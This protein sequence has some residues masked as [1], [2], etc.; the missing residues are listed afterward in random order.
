MDDATRTKL[1]S[2]LDGTVLLPGDPTYD[3]TRTI[4]NAIVDRRPAV[5]F[6]CASVGDVVTAVRTARERD[7]EIGIRCGGHSA[8]GHAVPDG[9]LMID[10]SPL[11]AVRVD[12]GQRRAVV[13]GGALLGALDR[14]SQQ[15]GL[16]ASVASPSAA[17][18]AGWLGRQVWLATTSC[19]SRSSRRTETCCAST[20]TSIPT[21]TGRC[22]A[23]AETSAS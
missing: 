2:R 17:G 12:P 14:A 6:R 1:A 10:L 21:S 9:G 23:V 18:W 20:R 16:A 7:L 19:R 11:R 3:E 4:W 22:A 13:Q 8:A 5:I 15:F